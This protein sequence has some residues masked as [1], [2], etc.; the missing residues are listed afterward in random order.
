MKTTIPSPR[1]CPQCNKN[2]MYAEIIGKAY[3]ACDI[4]KKFWN[5]DVKPKWD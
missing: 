4:C 1:R 3:L 2:L 5:T